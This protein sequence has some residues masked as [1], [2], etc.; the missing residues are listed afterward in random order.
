MNSVQRIPAEILQ[1]IFKDIT[2][3]DKNNL[4]HLQLTCKSWSVIA[5]NFL[6]ESIALNTLLYGTS[7]NTEKTKER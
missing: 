4:I 6:Y 5:Q 1:I 7:I 2:A 3:H